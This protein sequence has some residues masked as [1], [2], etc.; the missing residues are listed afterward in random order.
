MGGT[1][2]IL[3]TETKKDSLKKKTEK[4]EKLKQR[5]MDL[6]GGPEEKE[7]QKEEGKCR[8][9]GS[10]NHAALP[11]QKKGTNQPLAAAAIG[12]TNSKGETKTGAEDGKGNACRERKGRGRGPNLHNYPG[13]EKPLSAKRES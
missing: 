13:K 10:P 3:T 9:L 2:R 6:L 7:K 8:H 5:G 12:D 1:G 11:E 4:R